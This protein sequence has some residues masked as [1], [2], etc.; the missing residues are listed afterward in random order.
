MKKLRK[1][2][3]EQGEVKG[4]RIQ[5]NVYKKVVWKLLKLETAACDVF[6]EN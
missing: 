4:R 3:K 2:S 5:D 6:L 1:V